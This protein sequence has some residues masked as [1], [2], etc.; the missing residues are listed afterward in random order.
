MKRCLEK[1]KND[2]VAAA[3]KAVKS[4]LKARFWNDQ[5]NILDFPR[6]RF[7][8]LALLCYFKHW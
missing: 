5:L 1:E 7:T 6:C 4:V 2:T 3:H 8:S